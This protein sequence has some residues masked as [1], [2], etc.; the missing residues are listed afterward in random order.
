[1]KNI[2]Y[3]FFSFIAFSPVALSATPYGKIV[4][5]EAREWGLHI[6]TDF[7]WNDL[8]CSVNVGDTYMYDFRYDYTRNSTDSKTEVAMLLAAFTAQQ[9][10]SF[11]IYECTP[12]NKR[13]IIGYIRI[14]Q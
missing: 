6:Q 13:P 4:G 14:K 11:H 8:G 1:M 3:L 5:I 2:K 9:S 7:G 10:V 12:D